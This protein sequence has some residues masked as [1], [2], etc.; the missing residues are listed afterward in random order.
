VH[1]D[2]VRL[3]APILDQLFSLTIYRSVNAEIP[4]LLRF[5]LPNGLPNL[6]SLGIDQ[7]PSS[8]RKN[9]TIEGSLWFESEDGTFKP[10]RMTPYVSCTKQE[11]TSNL[12]FGHSRTPSCAIFSVG[13][14][15]V[16]FQRCSASKEV[17]DERKSLQICL[18]Q[19]SVKPLP[20]PSLLKGKVV[21]NA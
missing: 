17:K 21:L 19:P 2:D 11:T 9:K 6:K 3:L 12:L 7:S 18:I 14:P 4:Y 16:T 20:G 1:W 15:T 10:F 8:S 13:L 5:V